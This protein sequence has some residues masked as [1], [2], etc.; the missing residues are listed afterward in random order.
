MAGKAWTRSCVSITVFPRKKPSQIGR[1]QT[2]SWMMNAATVIK[3]INAP[4]TPPPARATIRKSPALQTSKLPQYST[5]YYVVDVRGAD[6]LALHLTQQPEAR[7]IADAPA[8]GDFFYYAVVTGTNNNRLTR[9]IDLRSADSPVLHFNI[10]Y[11]LAAHD[12]FGYVL[13]SEDGGLRLGHPARQLYN[14]QN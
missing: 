7:L 4:L 10:W 11:D 8:N 5:D 13:V 1:W 3:S 14:P 6:Q 12:E 2:I 9:Q